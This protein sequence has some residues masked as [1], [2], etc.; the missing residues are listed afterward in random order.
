MSIFLTT[1]PATAT[2]Q[3]I[4]TRVM[5]SLPS[6]TP[7]QIKSI[8]HVEKTRYFRLIRVVE[9]VLTPLDRCA[10]VNFTDRATAEL[11]AAAWAG[12]FEMDDQPL[13]VKWGR[14]R[15]AKAKPV[16]ES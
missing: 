11:A 7:A 9:M 4:R 6:L 15:A 13:G 1:L 2:E 8:V 5:Q 16:A 12:G 10:F 3:S 14:S